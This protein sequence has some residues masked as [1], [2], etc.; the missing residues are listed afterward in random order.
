MLLDNALNI[1][2]ILGNRKFNTQRLSYIVLR[3]FNTV[4]HGI[5]N[6]TSQTM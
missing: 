1:K 3:A 6:L 2:I 5:S 4:P